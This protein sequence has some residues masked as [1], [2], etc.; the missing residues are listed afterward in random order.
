MAGSGRLRRMRI[1]RRLVPAAP[2]TTLLRMITDL[3]MP[4]TPKAITSGTVAAAP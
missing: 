2:L 4:S 1:L 3:T